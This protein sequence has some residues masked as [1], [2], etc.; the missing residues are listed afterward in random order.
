MTKLQENSTR[1]IMLTL[2]NAMDIPLSIVMGTMEG[3]AATT[4]AGTI[5]GGYFG[6]TVAG[7]GL[8]IYFSWQ[9]ISQ[10]TQTTMT[11][12]DI[13]VSFVGIAAS[14][15]GVVALTPVAVP[16]AI[17]VTA[18]AVAGGASWYSFIRFLYKEH[19]KGISPGLQPRY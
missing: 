13:G 17:T 19:N 3:L 7:N 5:G 9:D 11:Y 12:V 2:W 4:A 18:I 16:T 10:G 6:I 14:F 1:N 8:S 15:V